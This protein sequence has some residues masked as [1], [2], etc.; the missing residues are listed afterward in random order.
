MRA[1]FRSDAGFTLLE[2]IV[3]L[4]IVS[5]ALTA[6]TLSQRDAYRAE[7]RLRNYDATLGVARSQLDRVVASDGLKAGEYTGSYDPQTFWRM[8]VSALPDPRSNTE[9][10]RGEAFWIELVVSNRQGQTIFKLQTAKA[11]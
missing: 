3:A 5:L 7:A 1:H 2:V 6:F 11:G 10:A 4:A 8:T 9:Q